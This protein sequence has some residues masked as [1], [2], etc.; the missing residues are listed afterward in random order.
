[1]ELW[2][3]ETSSWAARPMILVLFGLDK[4]GVWA[5]SALRVIHLIL[6]R[7][8]LLWRVCGLWSGRGY[9]LRASDLCYPHTHTYLLAC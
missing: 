4:R 1:M 6:L 3:Q 7:A 9:V 2:Q 8:K 5:R